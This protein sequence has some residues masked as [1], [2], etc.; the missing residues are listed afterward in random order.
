M[1]TANVDEVFIDICRQMLR[2]DDAIEAMDEETFETRYKYD[3]HSRKRRRRKRKK[4]HPKC[5]IL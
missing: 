4:D 1:R 5:V 2:V 3:E